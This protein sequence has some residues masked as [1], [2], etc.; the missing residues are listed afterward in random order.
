VFLPKRSPTSTPITAKP[1]SSTMPAAV[2]GARRRGTVW[3][4]TWLCSASQAE[5]L[6]AGNVHL[7]R[8]LRS[9]VSPCMSWTPGAP[10]YCYSKF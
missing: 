9:G 10:M 6:E 8:A 7:A 2:R 3:G 5:A 1:S 4:V